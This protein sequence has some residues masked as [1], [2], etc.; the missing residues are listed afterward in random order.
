MVSILKLYSVYFRD[1]RKDNFFDL[2]GHSLLLAQLQ[3]RLNDIFEKQISM[4]DL[5]ANPTISDCSKLFITSTSTDEGAP[6]ELSATKNNRQ[7][8]RQQQIK[9][10]RVNRRALRNTNSEI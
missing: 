9:R 4:V 1:H 8:V 10:Q 6:L 2:G 3:R 5:F 7:S